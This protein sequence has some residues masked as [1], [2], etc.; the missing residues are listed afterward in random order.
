MKIYETHIPSIFKRY[1]L[2]TSILLAWTTLGMLHPTDFHRS[3]DRVL[4]SLFSL[5]TDAHPNQMMLGSRRRLQV[6]SEKL[7]TR[8]MCQVLI[9]D[10]A[11]NFA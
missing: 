1:R 2:F 11:A 8:H 10:H 5:A 4:L 9:K 6:Q 3:F 7:G